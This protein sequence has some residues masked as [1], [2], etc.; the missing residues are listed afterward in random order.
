MYLSRCVLAV[1]VVLLD[2]MDRQ[3]ALDVIEQRRLGR[4]MPGQQPKD[5]DVEDESVGRAFGPIF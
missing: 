3:F 1:E 2:E 5:L 4:L